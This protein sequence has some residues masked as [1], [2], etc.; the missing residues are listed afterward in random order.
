M[1]HQAEANSFVLLSGDPA[2]SPPLKPV[3]T[4]V[5]VH[6]RTL[7]PVA[8]LALAQQVFAAQQQGIRTGDWSDFL[9]LLSDDIEFRAPSP[10]VP[11]AG[12]HGKAAVAALLH[13]FATELAVRGELI[14][15]EPIVTNATTV[16]FEFLAQGQMAGE[17]VAYA[18]VV[19]YEIHHGKVKRLREYI[20]R[21]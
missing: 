2:P 7:A 4:G 3:Q 20:G 14:Q 12:L 1:S 21:Q 16:A 13:K 11:E 6:E 9:A 19:F 15:Q 17:T 10:H 18:M 8:V 5:I